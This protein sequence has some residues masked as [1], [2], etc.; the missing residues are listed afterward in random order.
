MVLT[1]LSRNASRLLGCRKKRGR[2]PSFQD[3]ESRESRGVFQSH[4][5]CN[6]DDFSVTP[7]IVGKMRADSSVNIKT[8]GVMNY[9]CNVK[10]QGS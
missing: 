5:Q 1:I 8:G 3:L 2:R 9:W 4:S 10:A 6:A 7:S